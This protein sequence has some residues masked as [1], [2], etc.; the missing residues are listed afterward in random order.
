MTNESYLSGQRFAVAN[1]AGRSRG[2]HVAASFSC[3]PGFPNKLNA[4]YGWGPGPHVIIATYLITFFNLH[5]HR[6]F[7]GNRGA[8]VVS[9]VPIIL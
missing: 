9:F 1:K 4:G 2:K 3:V 5:V 6:F 8:W 7:T